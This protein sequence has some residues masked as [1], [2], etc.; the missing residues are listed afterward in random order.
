VKLR[1][2]LSIVAFV[3]ALSLIGCSNSATTSTTAPTTPK[4]LLALDG[5]GAGNNVNVFPVNATTGVLG[6]PVTGSAFDLGLTRAMTAAVHPNGHFV[7]AADGNDGSIHAWDV[8]ETTGIPVEIAPKVINHS[9]SYF[10]SGNYGN[11]ITV[12]P[13]G[14]FLYSAN[15]DATVGAYTIGTDGSLT[16]L[17]DLNVGACATGMITAN[18]SFVWV[19]DTCYNLLPGIVRPV[20]NRTVRNG[21]A[22][23]TQA[24]KCETTGCG[25]GAGN[26]VSLSIGADGTLTRVGSLSLTNV[27]AQLVSIQV[28]P[29]AKFLYVGENGG[30]LYSLSVATDGSLTQLAVQ[31]P[32]SGTPADLAHSP[33]GKFL[34]ATSLADHAGAFS[35]DTTSGA[36]TELAASP[37]TGGIGQIIVDVTGQFVYLGDPIG[38]GQVIGYTRDLTTGALTPIGNTATAGNRAIAVGIIR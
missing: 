17:A 13:S 25:N 36:V 3:L 15:N 11:V 29:M 28:N 10:F 33:D 7:Y 37:Y 32:L 21:T 14:K 8:S 31:A 2:P 34:Y 38:S 5:Y 19:T 26:V 24:A 6:A 27:Y 1:L 23:N 35:V 9:A 20:G 18:D 16:H 22:D 30:Q 12:T 4:F